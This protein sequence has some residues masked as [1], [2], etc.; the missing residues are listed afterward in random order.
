M[1]RFPALY[2]ASFFFPPGAAG[3][4]FLAEKKEI[5]GAIVLRAR[6]R[7]NNLS[8]LEH[9]LN[10]VFAEFNLHRPPVGAE[11]NLPA[12]DFVD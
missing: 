7:A 6:Q 2:P 4:F 9:F 1:L 3:F 10:F 5:G 12:L 11:L 8:S